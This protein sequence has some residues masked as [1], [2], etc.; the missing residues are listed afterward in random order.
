LPVEDVRPLCKAPPV[1]VK[2]RPTCDGSNAPV[3]TVAPTGTAGATQ[4]NL[5]FGANIKT[6]TS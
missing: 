2:V 4:I 1:F 6:C 5:G 3:D